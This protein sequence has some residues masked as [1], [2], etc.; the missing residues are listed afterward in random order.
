MDPNRCAPASTVTDEQPLTLLWGTWEMWCDMPQRQQGQG[1]EN[2]NWLEQV[3]SIGLFDSAEGFWGIFNCTILPSQ[4]PPNGSYYLFRKHIAPMWEHEANRRGGKWVIPFTGKSSRS[5]GDLQP[6]DEA[7]QTLCLSAI[8]ELFPGDEE[9]VCGV[10][11]SRGRQRTLPSGHATSVL[12]EWKLC[13][14]TRSADNRGSQMRIAEYIR[15]Q[16]HLQSLSKET[17]RDGKSGE[18]DTLME[19]PRSPDRSP[20]AKTREASSIPS[21]MTYVAHRDLME[22]KQEFVKGGSSVAQAF[23]PKYTL[24]IDVRGEAV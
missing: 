13:L 17:S 3:K 22:A 16:L 19:M 5:E 2:T 6:V 24:A 23:R 20:V 12:S 10:T 15:K 11:V 9:E 21:A 14:W 7:W 1:T 8:G 4:L 18:N